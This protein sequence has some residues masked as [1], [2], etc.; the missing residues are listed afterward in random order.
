MVP[1]LGFGLAT[2]QGARSKPTQQTMVGCMS[3]M[4]LRHRINPIP[5]LYWPLAWATHQENPAALKLQFLNPIHRPETS[6]FWAGYFRGTGGDINVIQGVGSALVA[7]ATTDI[8]FM[9]STGNI[10]SG[11]YTLLGI[12]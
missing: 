4:A 10:T 11:T 3:M 5:K 12:M 6:I 9:F 2:I 7:A 1:I 8:R